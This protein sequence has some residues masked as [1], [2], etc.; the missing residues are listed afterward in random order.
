MD[1]GT[2]TGNGRDIAWDAAGNL[3][4]LSSGQGLYRELS[5][6][7]HTTTT[8]TWNGTTYTFD[9]QRTNASLTGDYNGDGKVD[10]Q[11][12]VL[13]RKSPGTFGG[14]PA[15]Y[16]A[17]RGNFGAGGPGAGSSLSG[18]SVP[19]PS[20]IALVAFGLIAAAGCRRRLA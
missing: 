20:S 5:P 17:W 14:D 15:G 6:G 9:S 4:Y 12:Y 1:S 18:A 16:N 19:E 11:D 10:A 2:N 7:G 8:L 3:Y 13:W